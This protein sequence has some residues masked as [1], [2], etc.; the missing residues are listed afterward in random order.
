MSR[1]KTKT[2][3]ELVADI[4]KTFSIFCKKRKCR[5]CPYNECDNC[6]LEYLKDLIEKEFEEE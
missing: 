2:E 4:C 6:K 5:D 1:R 3:R